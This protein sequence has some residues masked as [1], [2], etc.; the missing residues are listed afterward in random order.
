MANL[1]LTTKM[2]ATSL[3][4]KVRHMGPVCH[5]EGTHL[6][7]DHWSGLLKQ[8]FVGSQCHHNSTETEIGV[9]KSTANAR[10]QFLLPQKFHSG[11]KSGTNALMCHGTML[12]NKNT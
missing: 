7:T 5:A 3:A 4:S 10:A 9:K 6:G 1:D 2:N 11:V 8:Y 12:K